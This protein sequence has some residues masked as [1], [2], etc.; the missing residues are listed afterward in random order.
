[1]IE[2]LQLLDM[3]DL[4]QLSNENA[5]ILQDSMVELIENRRQKEGSSIDVLAQFVNEGR[6]SEAFD[7]IQNSKDIEYIPFANTTK[8]PDRIIEAC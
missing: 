2:R 4:S 1:M 6:A 3:A 8:M 7:L 5:N